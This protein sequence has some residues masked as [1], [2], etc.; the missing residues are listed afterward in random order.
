MSAN[1]N[2]QAGDRQKRATGAK[3][4]RW[5]YWLIIMYVVGLLGGDDQWWR[6]AW[7]FLRVPSI[8]KTWHL[9]YKPI[10]NFW[11]CNRNMGGH[12][13]VLF[14]ARSKTKTWHLELWCNL[15][16][17]YL[18]LCPGG[19]NL[20]SS[21]WPSSPRASGGALLCCFSSINDQDLVWGRLQA[22]RKQMLQLIPRR[23]K[24]H[25]TA[26]TW[27]LYYRPM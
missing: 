19:R 2:F 16:N 9:Y 7:T 14:S 24:V 6:L 26:K 11:G 5:E 13:A 17:H 12:G 15:Q 1:V 10:C 3:A 18:W 8:E 20:G 27:Q 21:A 23:I 22:T 4:K 25:S